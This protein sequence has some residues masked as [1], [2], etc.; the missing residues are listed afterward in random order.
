MM[1]FWDL[2]LGMDGSGYWGGRREARLREAGKRDNRVT[3]DE[4]PS[5][6]K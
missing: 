3:S 1:D 2:G 5:L 6:K 4:M